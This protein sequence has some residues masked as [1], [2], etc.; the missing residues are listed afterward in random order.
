MELGEAY[1]FE[2]VS[3]P[4]RLEST[5]AGTRVIIECANDTIKGELESLGKTKNTVITYEKLQTLHGVKRC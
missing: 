2:G 1:A 3:G 4:S 5:L